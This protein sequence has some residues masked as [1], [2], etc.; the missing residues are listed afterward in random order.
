MPPNHTRSPT[1]YNSPCGKKISELSGPYLRVPEHS[2]HRSGG[3]FCLFIASRY[4]LARAKTQ[5]G[6]S[7]VKTIV[8]VELKEKNGC[9]V[10]QW[11]DKIFDLT[12][13]FSRGGRYRGMMFETGVGIDF[14]Q[15]HLI[16]IS[17]KKSLERM[18]VV[19]YGSTPF[20][21]A[22]GRVGVRPSIHHR[23]FLQNN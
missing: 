8:R 13:C 20:L 3:S 23:F 2:A 4:L 9:K 21:Q 17:L 19:D 18:R 12:S 1:D 16:L 14:W 22:E 15:N 7:G 6:Y 5:N 11:V 10:I